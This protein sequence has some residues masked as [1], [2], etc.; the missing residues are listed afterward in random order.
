MSGPD[1]VVIGKSTW[2][3][4][5]ARSGSFIYATAI[6]QELDG[7]YHVIVP[8]SAAQEPRREQVGRL[9]VHRMG[10]RWSPSFLLRSTWAARQLMRDGTGSVLLVSSDPVGGLASELARVGTGVP[11]VLTVQGE[12]IAPGLA[13]GGFFRRT[14]LTFVVRLGLRRATAVR[15]VNTSLA[16]QARRFTSRP[17]YVV[18]TRVDTSLFTPTSD[19]I[20]SSGALVVASLIPLKNVGLVLEAWAELPWELRRQGLTIIGDGPAATPLKERSTSLGIGDTVTFAGRLSH[21]EVSQALRR[22]RVLLL[23]SL[24]EGHPRVVL[25]ALACGVPVIVS[26]IDPHQELLTT[27]EDAATLI[28]TKDVAACSSAL[29]GL[30]SA[31]TDQWLSISGLARQAA[32]THYDFDSNVR[33]FVSMIRAVSEGVAQ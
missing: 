19:P 31:P 9:T 3:S 18:G 12:I 16:S 28:G 33:T 5:I 17:V 22:S 29:R 26:D 30:L 10:S 11:H 13:Y 8:R 21:S 4:P 6:A 14:A 27:A 20:L 1:L 15:T 7:D 24:T 23:T 2:P 32:L 25:E